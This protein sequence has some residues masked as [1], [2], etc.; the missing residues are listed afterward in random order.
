MRRRSEKKDQ[1][2]EEGEEEENQKKE[3]GDERRRR[4]RRRRK[5]KNKVNREDRKGPQKAQHL[6]SS[7]ESTDKNS[8]ATMKTVNSR[9]CFNQTK[10]SSF[11]SP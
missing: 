3:D 7:D 1:E 11:H 6:I 9:L 4:R 5:K 10:I 2:E 8:Q